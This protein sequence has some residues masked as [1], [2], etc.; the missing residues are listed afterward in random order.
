MKNKIL[1]LIFLICFPL[2]LSA[3]RVVVIKIEGTINPVSASFIHDGIEKASREK[4]A[5]L[6]IQLN[7][8]GGLLQSTRAI[9]SDMLM[10]PVPVVV[11]VSPSG[12][13]A[14]S[15]GVFITLAAHIAAMAPGTNIGAAHPINMGGKTD[16]VMNIKATNDAAAFIR[17]I[18]E[19]RKRNLEWSEDAVRNSLSITANE[20]LK[21]NVIDYIAPD[22][23]TLLNQID[24]RN[25]ELS[26]GNVTLHTKGAKIQY[27]E[28]STS[29]KLLDFISNP[30]IAYILLML[31]MLGIYFELFN[32]GAVL[33]GVVGVISL[34]LAFFA[35]NTLPVNYAG[36]M[37]IIFS[38]V[39]FLLEIKVVSHGVLAI[40][41]VVS[42]FLGSVMLFKSSSSLDMI[43]ISTGIIISV[44]G[45]STAFFLFVIGLGLRAQRLKTVT[46]IHILLGQIGETLTQLDPQGQLQVNGEVWTAESTKGKISKGELVKV[47]KVSGLTLFVEPLEHAV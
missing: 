33:P 14:G 38:L 10:S 9:V 8:P 3:Q 43:K 6:V 16:S 44:T 30:D 4:A 20:A 11:H 7:T 13:H 32:P 31:G 27:V 5:C 45:I 21:N 23:T 47:I 18:A 34:I 2:M 46:G 28:M 24:G 29:E 39:L 26:T 35:M 22:E 17:S 25:V 36:L 37:L 15:A 41:G 40:G 1:F 12:A 42:L 19:K